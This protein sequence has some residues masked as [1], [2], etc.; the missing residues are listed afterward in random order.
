MLYCTHTGILSIVPCK[1]ALA[2]VR[3]LRF[4]GCTLSRPVPPSVLRFCS[5]GSALLLGCLHLLKFFM[6]LGTIFRQKQPVNLFWFLG[7][8]DLFLQRLKL[9]RQAAN[10]HSEVKRNLEPIKGLESSLESIYPILDTRVSCKSSREHTR[11]RNSV[12]TT[13]V[14]NILIRLMHCL[15]LTNR[16]LGVL[17]FPE[18][19]NV[20]PARWHGIHTLK[21]QCNLGSNPGEV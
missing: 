10:A 9:Q 13:L 7:R 16:F 14:L 21:S 19:Y 17:V 8:H 2:P 18:E 4:K 20:A 3:C 6:V 12:H 1:A 15:V 5:D 11:K